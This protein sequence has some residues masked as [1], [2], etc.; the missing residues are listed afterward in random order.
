MSSDITDPDEVA[1]H[2]AVAALVR[3]LQRNRNMAAERY[4]ESPTADRWRDLKRFQIAWFVAA[5][6]EAGGSADP[7]RPSNVVPLWTP[8]S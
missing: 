4:F 3:G 8:E 5:S 1:H 7:H 6:I 2:E